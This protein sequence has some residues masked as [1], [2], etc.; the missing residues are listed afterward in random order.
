MELDLTKGLDEVGMTVDF[1]AVGKFFKELDDL[2]DHGF[3]VNK[4][5]YKVLECLAAINS[6]RYIMNKNPTMEHLAAEAF[7]L[8]IQ[9]FSDRGITC[10]VLA[11]RIYEKQNDNVAE[12]RTRDV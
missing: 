7:Q 10:T 5:D 4:D 1:F 11:A 2:W 9:F 6:K 12:W 3:L 8:A